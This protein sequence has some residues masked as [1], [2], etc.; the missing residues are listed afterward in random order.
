ML[1]LFEEDE[2]LDVLTETFRVR[3]AEIGD[4]AGSIKG[5]GG[6]IGVE[7][8]EFLRGLEEW[9]RQLFKD[10]H[11]SAKAGKKWLADVAKKV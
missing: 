6:G 3:A 5:I 7:G 10:R 4:F 9:E 8:T 2:I 11:E 1:E